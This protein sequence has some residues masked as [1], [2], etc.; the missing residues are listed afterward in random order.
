V[1]L[2]FL[3]AGSL[4]AL[5][6][7][8]LIGSCGEQPSGNPASGATPK[9]TLTV[10][11]IPAT[12]D[13][14]TVR[15]A[16]TVTAT[17]T[18]PT[19]TSPAGTTSQIYQTPV[20]E[21]TSP[22]SSIA[23]SHGGPVQDYV[24]LIDNLRKLGATVNP[25]GDV[26]QPFFSTKG[27]VIRVNGEEIQIFEYPSAAAA[28]AEVGKISPEGSTIGTSIVSWTANP[29]FFQ[30][31]RLVVLYIGTNS[32]VTQLLTTALGSQVAGR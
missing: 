5:V 27:N 21:A 31:E 7:A 24:S 15:I 20:K 23:A 19:T 8:F 10:I 22:S 26:T 13:T 9:S 16:P 1:R 30:K 32:G 17:A 2:T 12:Y 28:M 14:R 18:V 3:C 11:A 6:L 29:H 4:I 25:V